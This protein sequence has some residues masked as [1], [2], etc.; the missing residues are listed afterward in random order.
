[1][2]STQRTRSLPCRGFSKASLGLKPRYSNSRRPNSKGSSTTPS[3]PSIGRN[4]DCSGSAKIRHHGIQR[5]AESG[6]SSRTIF[7]ADS[8]FKSSWR[9]RNSV[10]SRSWLASVWGQRWWNAS[11][12]N[13][14]GFLISAQLED[15]QSVWQ[16]ITVPKVLGVPSLEVYLKLEDGAILSSE[17]FYHRPP[18]RPFIF[19]KGDI[20]CRKSFTYEKGCIAEWRAFMIFGLLNDVA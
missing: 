12:I 9:R 11:G 2:C 4:S 7:S 8:C 6:E 16:R 13:Q 1:M 5:L 3:I 15:D 18:E 20:S 14:P 17:T 10:V 19:R